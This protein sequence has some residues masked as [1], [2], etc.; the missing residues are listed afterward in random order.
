MSASV[1]PTLNACLNATAAVA[2]V[3]GVLAIR[4]RRVAVHR[5]AMLTAFA[6]STVFL[7]SYLVY[8]YQAGSKRFEGP[9]WL[10]VMY[11]GILLTHTVLA[12]AIVPLVVTTLYRALTRQFARHV[13][14]ARWTFP[15]WLY[16]SVPGVVVYWM[17]YHG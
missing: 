7:V 15:L 1:L 12:V 8:H 6:V 10:R 2:I 4:R 16:V 5:A 13:P 3:T 11:L 17:L 14:L 9:G